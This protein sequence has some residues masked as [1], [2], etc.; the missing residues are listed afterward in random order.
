MK[1]NSIVLYCAFVMLA[2][3]GASFYCAQRFLDG[4]SSS[5][6]VS[7]AAVAP[8]ARWSSLQRAL[9]LKNS[10]MLKFLLKKGVDVNERDAQGRTALHYAASLG[11]V[12]GVE[13]L[14]AH[15]ATAWC[16]DNKGYSPL[17]CAAGKGRAAWVPQAQYAKIVDYLT[18]SSSCALYDLKKRTPLHYAA[19]HGQDLLV[20]QLLVKDAQ[21]DCQDKFG[22]TPLHY[23]AG[24]VTGYR[25]VSKDYDKVVDV[26]LRAGAQLEKTD[27]SGKV[28]LH[29]AAASGAS[30]VVSLLTMQGAFLDCCDNDAATPLHY[31]AGKDTLRFKPRQYFPHV[32][33]RAQMRAYGRQYERALR[34]HST[35]VAHLCLLGASGQLLDQ[36]G[37]TALDY[38]RSSSH[39]RLFFFLEN[40]NRK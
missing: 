22:R 9:Y 32:R 38:A 16:Q 26:L 3:L 11:F 18:K 28:P 12:A 17:H 35:I 29:Y 1:I 23:A 15:G 39:E 37:K 40:S 34:E 21:V 25:S 13:L 8:S 5:E 6:Q 31:A 2:S 7:L 30:G 4:V 27:K 10:S 19:M 24:A 20:A 36:Q 14:C 33:Y